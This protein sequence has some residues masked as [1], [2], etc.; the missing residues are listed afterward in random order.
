MEVAIDSSWAAGVA[1][2]S[3]RVATFTLA[4]PIFGRFIPGVGR[5]ALVVV[6]GFFLAAPVPVA[7][8]G[9]LIGAGLANALVGAALG[10]LTGILLHIFQVAGGMID[11]SS[12][13]SVSGVLDPMTGQTEA[14][15]GRMFGLAAV[16]MFMVLGGDRLLVTGLSR[17]VDAIPLDGMPDLA[18]GL[19]DL[20][21][22]LLGKLML[23]SVEL[24]LPAIAALF[25][26][27]LAL[28]LANRLVPQMNAFLVGLP[29]KI[30]VTLALVTLVVIA[31]PS[32]MDGVITETWD[33]VSDVITG[34]GGS[35]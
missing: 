12:G 8:I 17:S 2:A 21:V 15:F 34:L 24:A 32:V 14:V 4:S 1:L 28:G 27:E 9:D 16:I 5:I 25:L 6:L 11:F 26:L 30:L 19:A 33:I 13:L 23:A 7:G 20:S 10:F 18:S 35:Q 29:A 22:S 3:T 31:F